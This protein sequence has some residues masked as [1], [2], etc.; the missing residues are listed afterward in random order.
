MQQIIIKRPRMIVVLQEEEIL[1]MLKQNPD[2]WGLAL[3]R[4]K[5]VLRYEKSM[6]RK[7]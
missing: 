4:G 5:S 7:G 3:K 1:S 2:I 6:D